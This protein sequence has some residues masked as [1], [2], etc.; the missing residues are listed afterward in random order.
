[1]E[2]VVLSEDVVVVFVKIVF[3]DA[4]DSGRELLL[5]R[6]VLPSIISVTLVPSTNALPALIF[7]PIATLSVLLIVTSFVPGVQET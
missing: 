3:T 2:F 1:M 4:F 6:I 5:T 7:I